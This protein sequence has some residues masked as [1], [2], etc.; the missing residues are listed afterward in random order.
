[1]ASLQ[2]GVGK[3]SP[4]MT[5]GTGVLLSVVREGSGQMANAV[6]RGRARVR[7]IKE[8]YCPSCC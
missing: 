4:L 8:E 2:Q 1:M 6:L 7:G 5:A 3:P